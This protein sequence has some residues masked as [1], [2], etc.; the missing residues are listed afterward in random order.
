MRSCFS[1]TVAADLDHFTLLSTL[2][3]IQVYYF[4]PLPGYS[5]D[6][7]K[8]NV[9]KCYT[10]AEAVIRQATQL[11][12]E[13]AFLHYAPHF[14]FRHLLLATCVILSVHFSSYTK[15]FQAD[16]MDELVKEAIRCMRTCSVQGND[17]HTRGP[18]MVENF[19]NMRERLPRTTFA[20]MGVSMFT[21]RLG[22]SLAFDCLRRWKKDVEAA[23]AM[24]LNPPAVN[25]AGPGTGPESIRTYIPF[26]LTP[27]ILYLAG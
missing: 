23:R 17:L 16:S 8:R 22:A 19:W 20:D 9:L 24:D 11:Q 10:T 5:E 1:L 7:L 21:H 18:N 4:I 2:L 13:R 3:E 26:K 6:I 15:G 12:R 27:R 25:Q 14:I